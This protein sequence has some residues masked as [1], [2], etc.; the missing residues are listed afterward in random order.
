[1][2]LGDESD[3]WVDI[4]EC[5]IARKVSNIIVS[6]PKSSNVNLNHMQNISNIQNV[7]IVNESDVSTLLNYARRLAPIAAVFVLRMVKSLQ[8]QIL[9]GI[10]E[11]ITYSQYFCIISERL[12]QRKIIHRTG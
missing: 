2:F 9:D 12:Q 11:L 4:A 10:G 3:F 6:Q 5:L 8:Q 1:M 7:K